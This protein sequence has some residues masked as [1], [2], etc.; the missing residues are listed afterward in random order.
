MRGDPMMET[1]EAPETDVDEGTGTE[2][3]GGDESGGQEGGG[4]ESA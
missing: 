2:E 3:G 4:D 1:P